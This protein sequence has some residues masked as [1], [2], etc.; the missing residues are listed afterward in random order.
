MP[1]IPFLWGSSPTTLSSSPVSMSVPCFLWWCSQWSTTCTWSS[2]GVTL[3]RTTPGAPSSSGCPWSCWPPS[4]PSWWPCSSP[5]WFKCS[6]TQASSGSSSATFS[7][8]FSSSAHSGYARRRLGTAWPGPLSHLL[9][10]GRSKSTRRVR[11]SPPGGALLRVGVRTSTWP[12]T[13]PSS[14]IFLWSSFLG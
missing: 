2:L 1:R 4:F 5:T 13:P 6:T 11:F 12:H 3:A 10:P 8:P 14:V 7:R 9:L